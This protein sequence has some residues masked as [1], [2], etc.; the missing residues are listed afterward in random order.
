MQDRWIKNLDTLVPSFEE[1]KNRKLALSVAEAGLAGISTDNVVSRAIKLDGDILSVFEEKFD[2]KAFKRIKVVGFGKASCQ[3]AVALEKILGSRIHEGVV[4]GL[5]K[6]ECS[7]IET[8]AGTHPRPSEENS[9][10][11][12][13]I[14]Q[15][16]DN[17]TEDDLI[18]AIISGGGSALLCYPESECEQGRILYDS[19]LKSGKTTIELNT[20][21]KHISLLKGGGLAKIAYPATVVGL[22]FSDVPGNHFEDVASGPTYKDKSTVIDATHIIQSHNL[23][24]FE[25]N[26]TPKEDKY[27]EKV[28]NFVLVSNDIA[29]S[30][31]LKKAQELGFHTKIVSTELYDE[32]DVSL[33]KIFSTD[34]GGKDCF[35]LAAGDPALEIKKKGGSGGR[36]LYMGLRAVKLGLVDHGAVFIPLASDGMDNS[37]KAG[38]VVDEYTLAKIKERNLDIDEYLENYDAYNFFEK[39]EDM[40]NTGPTGANVSDLMILLKRHGK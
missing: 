25:L 19:F 29:V 34:T 9:V 7:Y 38:V 35:I 27:F 32:V 24:E 13:K 39:T 14:F 5:H 4:I 3:A 31:M 30:A 36:N 11:S 22:I 15:I 26:E 18:I 17:A 2:L 40:I 10:A 37:D 1:V 6:I 8:F 28:H 16:C 33:N 20:V 21:R 23:G 12:E